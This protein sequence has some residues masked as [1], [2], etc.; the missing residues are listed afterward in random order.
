[1]TG[2][3]YFVFLA[4][5]AATGERWRAALT[6]KAAHAGF[7]VT[8]AS[9]DATVLTTRAALRVDNRGGDRGAE[10]CDGDDS[11][12]VIGSAFRRGEVAAAATLTAS[13]AQMLRDTRGGALIDLFWGDYVAILPDPHDGT[14][15]V[16]APFGDLACY[17]HACPAG[18]MLASDIDLL[19]RLGDYAPRF[20]LDAIAAH[21]I[22]ADIRHPAT[23]LAGVRE[24]TGGERLSLRGNASV[25]VIWS[26]W[27]CVTRE[28]RCDD[29]ALAARRVADTVCEVVAARTAH[30]DV[31][32][33]LLSGGLDSS[34]VAAALARAQR[35]CTAIT[36]V[37]R[38]AGGDERAHARATASHLA[39]PLIEI[40]RDTAMVDIAHSAAAGLPYP[41]ARSF[42][43]ATMRAAETAAAS[44]GASAIVHGGGGDNVFCALQ[45]AAP[46]A[47]LIL[48]G[49]IGTDLP[50]LARDIAALAQTTTF[51]VLQQ[52][53]ARV[54][55]GRPDYRWRGDTSL[56]SVD[57]AGQREAALA[58]P[59][60]AAPPGTMPGSAAHVALVLGALSLV[61]SPDA[62]A[63]LP[64]IAVLLAQ[65]VIEACLSVPTWRWFD[66]G[67]NRA[68][69]RHGFSAMLPPGIAWRRSKGAMDSFIVELFERH[70]THLKSLLLDGMLAAYGL[71]DRAA[72]AAVLDDTA[73]TRGHD[74]ARVMRLADVEVWLRS[75]A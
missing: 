56:L 37:T 38:D 5:D 50:N 15:V 8:L 4:N 72:I 68:I 16:R 7:D 74:Y 40:V 57:A 23:C 36:M 33:L 2:G 18:M 73:P 46:V 12:V 25:E 26:P 6:A 66:R 13:E 28:R 62:R 27:S 60:L 17:Y 30:H 44:L 48:A 34:I 49:K 35:C 53:M 9:R 55:R 42:S 29:A 41:I 21:L 47:D 1:M 24:L 31:T 61:Q 43:Q 71:L 11:G 69:A 20:E 63:S 14:S 32:I 19:M 3:R 70:R 45:S 65:P 22:A 64:S 52:A 59:W 75:W 10:D 58:H 67:R 39:M 54:W 51:A